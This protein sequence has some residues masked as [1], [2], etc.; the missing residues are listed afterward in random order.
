MFDSMHAHCDMRQELQECNCC[1]F[2]VRFVACLLQMS[3]TEASQVCRRPWM[4][5][6]LHD[7]LRRQGWG[8]LAEQLDALQQDDPASI[9]GASSIA[10]SISC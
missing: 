8:D 6:A 10:D 4:R 3:P 7:W 1:R 5:G 2:G 9:N